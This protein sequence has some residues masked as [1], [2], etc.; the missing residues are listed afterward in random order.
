M[1]LTTLIPPMMNIPMR[2]P[3][4]GEGHLASWPMRGVKRRPAATPMVRSVPYALPRS[5]SSNMSTIRPFWI[6]SAATVPMTPMP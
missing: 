3:F 6:G 2:Q 4:S 5:S 1:P